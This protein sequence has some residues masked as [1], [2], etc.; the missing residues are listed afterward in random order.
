MRARLR[1]CLALG[2]FSV[3]LLGSLAAEIMLG[4][5]P[6]RW[7]PLRTYYLTGIAGVLILTSGFALLPTLGRWGA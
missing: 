1:L 2:V 5:M 3:C 7:G 6:A 4:K